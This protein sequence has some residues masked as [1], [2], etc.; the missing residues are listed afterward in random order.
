MGTSAFQNLVSHPYSALSLGWRTCL[1]VLQ[2]SSKG[3]VFTT[4]CKL[5]SY[6]SCLTWLLPLQLL[7]LFISAAMYDCSFYLCNYGSAT[8]WLNL[9]RRFCLYTIRLAATYALSVKMAILRGSHWLKVQ[10]LMA[11][12]WTCCILRAILP[13][14]SVMVRAANKEI[15]LFLKNI[16]SSCSYEDFYYFSLFFPFYFLFLFSFATLFLTVYECSRALSFINLSSVSLHLWKPCH[17][18]HRAEVGPQMD[19]MCFKEN[20]L[21]AASHSPSLQ[22]N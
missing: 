9:L 19:Y 22:F 11:C 3:K 2:V 18:L 21:S 8:R 6:Q 1:R 14:I 15:E 17:L 5:F 12:Q 16:L 4:Y 20:T 10:I 13:S 7:L